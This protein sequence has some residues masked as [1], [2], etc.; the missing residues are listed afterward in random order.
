[1]FRRMIL[2]TFGGALLAVVFAFGQTG[3]AACGD[4][5]PDKM[6]GGDFDSCSVTYTCP[7]DAPCY[8]SNVKCFYTGVTIL[9]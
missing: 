5:C 4:R 7:P 1:M 9:D 6:G 8:E 3:K 2:S